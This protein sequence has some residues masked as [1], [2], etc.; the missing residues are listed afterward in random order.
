MP[1]NRD[2]TITKAIKTTRISAKR[3]NSPVPSTPICKKPNKTQTKTTDHFVSAIQV[4]NQITILILP[5]ITSVNKKIRP[6]NQQFINPL[7]L[8]FRIINTHIY[9]GIYR[10]RLR[11][12]SLSLIR[13]SSRVIC[14]MCLRISLWVTLMYFLYR[15]IRILMGITNGFIFQYGE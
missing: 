12:R 8:T 10:L 9:M 4:P 11:M 7:I 6:P 1:K 3:N 15:M 5:I 13:N 14:C 2:L